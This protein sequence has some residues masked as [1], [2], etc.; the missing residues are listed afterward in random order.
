MQ[1]DFDGWNTVKKKTNKEASRLYTVREIWWCQFGIN[2]GT[3]QDGSGERFLRPAV[4]LRGFGPDACLVV[5]LT[6]SQRTHPLRF[7]VGIVD[8][9]EA[10]AN[11]SQI[12]VID[13]KRLVEKIG[14]LDKDIFK[15]LKKTVRDI[16]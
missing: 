1:K 8:E 7:P 14:F 4:I 9:K 6:K 5:P 13:T 11:L 3:E 2:I 16:L 10:R 12:R 15:S